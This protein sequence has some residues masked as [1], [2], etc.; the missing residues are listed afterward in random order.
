M[1]K[2]L[3]PLVLA[4]M[5]LAR[6]PA[7]TF[8]QDS[9]LKLIM[10]AVY[11]YNGESHSDVMFRLYKYEY[12]YKEGPM[13]EKQANFTIKET[14]CQ[15]SKNETL[16]SCEFLLGGL[17]K[18]CTAEEKDQ[19]AAL[20]VICLAVA[21]GTNPGNQNADSP[22]QEASYEDQVI[23]MDDSGETSEEEE[24]RDQDAF[25]AP[26]PENTGDNRLTESDRRAGHRRGR[27]CL[28]CVFDAFSRN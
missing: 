3:L 11:F 5:V 9:P 19:E 25:K 23:I 7:P 16:D 14:V 4:T 8:P 21:P 13:G 17:E 22:E 15:K 10:A 1:E 6:P 18:S 2:L 27:V 24:K 28:Q 12:D 26:K 20:S